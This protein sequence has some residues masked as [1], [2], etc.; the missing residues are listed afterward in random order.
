MDNG[1]ETKGGIAVQEKRPRRLSAWPLEPYV[2]R[3]MRGFTPRAFRLWPRLWAEEEWIP[4]IDIFERDG[5]I[6]LRAD[7]PGMKRE[8]IQVSVE[9]DLLTIKGRREEEKEIK[10]E[11]Y[12]SCER[13][14]GEF[15]RTMRL[16]SGV[17]ADAIDAKY[18]NGVLEVTVPRPATPESKAKNVTVK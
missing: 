5:K 7:L 11:H 13:S 1:K 9:G 16:P 10:E 6:V 4:D 12:Y 2:D 14:K 15:L 18:E 8:D 17:G 3:F